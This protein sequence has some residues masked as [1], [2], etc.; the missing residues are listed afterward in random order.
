M[1]TSSPP[2][3]YSLL[4]RRLHWWVAILVLAQFAFPD[5]MSDAMKAAAESKTPT[6]FEFF[7]ITAHVWI[8]GLIA[9]ALVFRLRLKYQSP[10][11]VGAGELGKGKSRLVQG[12]H[13]LMYLVLFVM[14]GSG[15]LYYYFELSVAANWHRQG[16]WALIVMVAIHVLAAFWHWKIRRDRV[17]QSMLGTGP[18]P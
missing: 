6:A 1:P 11:P 14:A 5:A 8:G 16:K 12:F 9:L 17:L 18:E 4:H 2:P 3:T 7:V 13:G 15:A 10:V